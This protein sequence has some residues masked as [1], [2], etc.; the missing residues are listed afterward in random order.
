MEGAGVLE[1]RDG[2]LRDVQ[3]QVARRASSLFAG[4]TLVW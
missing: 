1:Q 4:R 3:P 2:G